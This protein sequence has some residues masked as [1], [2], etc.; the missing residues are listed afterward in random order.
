MNSTATAVVTDFLRPFDALRSERAYLNVAR[1]LTFILGLLG[2]MLGLLFVNPEIKSLFDAFIM[3]IGLF[4][5]VLGGLFCLGVLTRRANGLG[6]F[7][8][9]LGGAA[10]VLLVGWFTEIHGYLYAMIGIA[11]CFLIGYAASLVLPVRQRNLDGL[12][13]YTVQAE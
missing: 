5:G 9:A 6:A 3:V 10:T 4:M 11:A 13:L 2:T 1:T 7:A 12:T 8:G